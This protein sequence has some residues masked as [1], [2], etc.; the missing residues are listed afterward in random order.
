M[1]LRFSLFEAVEKSVRYSIRALNIYGGFYKFRIYVVSILRYHNRSAT[2]TFSHQVDSSLMSEY[3][4]TAASACT[5]FL[6]DVAASRHNSNK[7][8][9]ALDFRNVIKGLTT[10]R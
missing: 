1:L 4:G 5:V 10:S 3:H 8:G 9:S 7:F 2:G 6:R